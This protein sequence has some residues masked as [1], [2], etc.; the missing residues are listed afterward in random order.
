MG[1]GGVGGVG[2]HL[3]MVVAAMVTGTMLNCTT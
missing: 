2:T 1:G 3:I